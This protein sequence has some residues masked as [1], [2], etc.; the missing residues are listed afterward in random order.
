MLILCLWLTSCGRK[1][2]SDSATLFKAEDLKI[3]TRNDFRD[4]KLYRYD[5]GIVLTGMNNANADGVDYQ[6]VYYLN[7]DCEVTNSFCFALKDN[8]SYF[9]GADGTLYLW[10]MTDGNTPIEITTDFP[11]I[12]EV[13]EESDGVREIITYDVDYNIVSD[14]IVGGSP[15]EEDNNNEDTDE[16]TSDSDETEPID[17]ALPA[18][19]IEGTNMDM[20]ESEGEF[21]DE[22]DGDIAT[23]EDKEPKASPKKTWCAD[24]LASERQMRN[25]GLSYWSLFAPMNATP[26]G[27]ETAKEEAYKA[28]AGLNSGSNSNEEGEELGQDNYIEFIAISSDGKLLKSVNLY[29]DPKIV[30][31][32]I[33]EAG[34]NYNFR[35]IG[36][37]KGLYLTTYECGIALNYDLEVTKVLTTIDADLRGADYVLDKDG[38]LNACFN[39]G[40][41]EVMLGGVDY[42]NSKIGAASIVPGER[43]YIN[44]FRGTMTDILTIDNGNIYGYTKG[45]SET[46]KLVDFSQSGV[47]TNYIISPLQI[48]KD[49]F[50]C[51]YNSLDDDMAHVCV[52]NRVIGESQSNTK[53]IIT[54]A[55]MNESSDIKKA[56]SAFNKNN[57]EYT[58]RMVDYYALYG[59]GTDN[60]YQAAIEKLNTDIIAGNMPDILII[61]SELPFNTYV[62][63]GLIE[64]L[65]PW[66]EQDREYSLEDYD[67]EILDVLDTE[68]NLY[69]LAPSYSLITMAIKAKYANGLDTMTYDQIIDAYKASGCKMFTEPTDKSQ[70]LQTAF[71]AANS[72]FINEEK[73]TCSFDSEAFKG[74][75]DFLE[76]FP[77]KT[78][79]SVFEDFYMNHFETAFRE[80]YSFASV[81]TIQSMSDYQR[82]TKGNFGEDVAFIGFPSVDGRGSSIRA[83]DALAMSSKSQF[84]EGCWEFMRYFISDDYQDKLQYG[85][86]IKKSSMEKTAEKMKE[87]LYSEYVWEG[88]MR[89]YPESYRLNGETIEMPPMTDE[90]IAEFM[91]I[92]HIAMQTADVDPKV[93][94]IVSEECK[95]YFNKNSTVDEIANRIQSRVQIYL[96]E[97]Q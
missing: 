88:V 49:R 76:L 12:V 67:T 33:F 79:D 34:Y 25:A 19:E 95:S 75:M 6:Y 94:N 9:V 86:P 13:S 14:V 40:G 41:P 81:C 62:N 60:G 23:N 90:D 87:K 80:D 84:K 16:A 22:S 63:K 50:L 58:I 74:L 68:G 82:I 11:E 78:A 89:R 53:K 96:F 66:I 71:I 36:D 10:R 83:N 91:S 24:S 5:G 1:I 73:A 15:K 17:E 65:Y 56:V 8:S 35:I 61:S 43:Y 4:F 39:K 64:D 59:E 93:I 77:E 28:N 20:E 69:R 48:D 85:L 52:L 21:T 31:S 2:D 70:V 97:T 57:S 54:L 7:N 46:T 30:E 32:K 37:E 72:Q 51:V 44:A 3:E 47:S 42:A 92:L 29:E 18:E 27:N 38:R 55:T 26:M 45:D